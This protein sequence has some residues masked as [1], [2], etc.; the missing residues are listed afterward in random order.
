VIYRISWLFY[1][2]GTALVVGSWINVVGPTLGW[3]GFGFGLVGW[4][5]KFLPGYSERH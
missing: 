1:I 4:G 5:M 3:I 2:V